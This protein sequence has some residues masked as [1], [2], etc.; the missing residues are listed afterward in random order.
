MPDPVMG[1]KACVY[2]ELKPSRDIAFEELISFLR[3]KGLTPYKL[4]ER[5]EIINKMPMVAEGQK[6]NKGALREDL[7]RKRS[8]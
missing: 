8:S 3:G 1:E 2:I 4:P 5:L 7:K 6:I